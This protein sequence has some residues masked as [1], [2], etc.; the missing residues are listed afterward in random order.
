[1]KN[2]HELYTKNFYGF[3]AFVSKYIAPLGI[4]VIDYHKHIPS[5]YSLGFYGMIA[6]I[7]FLV[8]FMYKGKKMFDNLNLNEFKISIINL[9]YCGF[10]YGII[11]LIEIIEKNNRKLSMVI[12]YIL[13]CQIVGFTLEIISLRKTKKLTK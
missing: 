11:T 1:M 2:L 4:I 10:L 8:V 5:N 6:F 7:F 3:L 9:I 12:L 13:I